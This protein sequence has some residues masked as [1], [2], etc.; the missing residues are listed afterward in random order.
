MKGRTVLVTGSTD[1]IGKATVIELARRG[2]KV[3]LHGKDREKVEQALDDVRRETGNNSLEFF[4]AELSSQRQ[5]RSLAEE[6][7][8]S[9]KQLHVLIN[10]A[11]TFQPQRRLTEDGLEVTF[12]V[13]YLAPFMLTHELLDL[14]KESA[15]K[16]SVLKESAQSRIV[17]V[18]SIAHWN[19]LVNWSNLQG[20]RRYDGFQAYALSK[21]G[22]ILFTYAL[23]K[24][25]QGTVV[26]AN[27]LHPG[28]VRTKLLRA[29]FG[30]YPGATP[31]EGSRTS[32][33]LA[34]S[35]KVE[36]ISGKY[37]ENCKPVQSS[38]ISYDQDLQEK[39]WQISMALAK[40]A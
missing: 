36:K 32:V 4:R 22:N 11:G 5:V 13:N 16:E 19:A 24:R 7:I 33:Y 28:V 39:L 20:E 12:A 15:L 38:P 3:L 37:F 34:S 26:T 9:Q 40:L 2:A 21:L 30:D 6:V 23:A 27:C 17:T 18:A 25:L 29:G 31:K 14:L 8:Q 10:N 1:G 35:P